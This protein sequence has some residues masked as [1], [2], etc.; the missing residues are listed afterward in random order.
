AGSDLI[1]KAFDAGYGVWLTY[2]IAAI[3]VGVGAAH[4]YKGA[5]AGFERYMSIPA[6]FR[7][8]LR[9]TC[10]FGLIAR[11]LTFLVIAFLMFR[12]ASGYSGD[13]TP[14]LERALDEISSWPYGWLLLSLTGLG[15]ISFGVYAITEGIYRRIDVGEVVR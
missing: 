6:R 11:G 4:I 12:G 8:W 14:G 15:L 3:V 5:K 1:G 9:P 7:S 13:E 10:R 2:A